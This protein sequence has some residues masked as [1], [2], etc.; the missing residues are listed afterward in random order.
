MQLH[1]CKKRTKV[2][3]FVRLL[4]LVC[5]KEVYK[6]AVAA[7]FNN[8]SLKHN[9]TATAVLFSTKQR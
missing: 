4:M 5:E 6:K 3:T 8:V 9:E 1:T 2:E 7:A